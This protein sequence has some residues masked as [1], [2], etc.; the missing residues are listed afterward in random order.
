M[1]ESTAAQQLRAPMR[2][3]AILAW[4]SLVGFGV[5][6]LGFCYLGALHGL[7]HLLGPDV[8]SAWLHLPLMIAADWLLGRMV[9]WF[10]SPG[11]IELLMDNVHAWKA[12][13]PT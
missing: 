4:S 7:E 11:D 6:L 3:R 2:F 9:K 13:R 1:S 5:G 12:A 8:H 10:G